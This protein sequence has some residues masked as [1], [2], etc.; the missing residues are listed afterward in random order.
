[1]DGMFTIN[2]D[3]QIK[4]AKGLDRES[5]A[6]YELTIRATDRGGKFKNIHQQFFFE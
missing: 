1:M 5:K 6:I 4:T 3:G 2:K